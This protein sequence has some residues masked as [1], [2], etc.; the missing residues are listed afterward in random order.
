MSFYTNTNEYEILFV[1][2]NEMNSSK[3]RGVFQTIYRKAYKCQR[4]AKLCVDKIDQH[5]DKILK[6]VIQF[7]MG[8][9]H[10]VKIFGRK[11][12]RYI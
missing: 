3:R 12:I 10:T 1:V 7:L 5:F 6:R 2:A 8:F 11:L 9:L 4:V